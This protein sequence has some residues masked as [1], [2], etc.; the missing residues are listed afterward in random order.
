MRPLGILDSFGVE[1]EVTSASKTEN[2]RRYHRARNINP[3]TRVFLFILVAFLAFGGAIPTASAEAINIRHSVAAINQGKGN[4]CWAAATAMLLNWKVPGLY[5]MQ[6]VATQG[7]PEFVALYNNAMNNASPSEISLDQ[8]KRLYAKLNLVVVTG[9]N[10]TINGWRNLLS[11]KGP[12]HVTIKP[13]GSGGMLHG[14][15]I[16]GLVGDGTAGGTDI[17]YND[18]ATGAQVTKKVV[19]FVA[20]YDGA[21]NWTNNIIHDP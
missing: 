13:N 15:L 7:G 21:A 16:T 19:D 17:F 9:V 14:V 1:V 20:M 18:P 5:T 6:S 10:P 8:E 2:W 4:L 3:L 11:V 12:L